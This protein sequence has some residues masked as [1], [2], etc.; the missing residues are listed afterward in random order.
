MLIVKLERVLGIKY[1]SIADNPLGFAH[2][3]C[4]F[5]V[6]LDEIRPHAGIAYNRPYITSWETGSIVAAARSKQ[7]RSYIFP[8]ASLN[9]S[10]K[11]WDC[12]GTKKTDRLRDP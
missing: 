3:W 2:F 4:D 8:S 9:H 12:K 1:S 5:L 10:N 7:Q 11:G 6:L